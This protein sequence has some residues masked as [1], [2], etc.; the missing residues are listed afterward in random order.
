MRELGE[1]A[2]ALALKTMDFHNENEAYAG[3]LCSH[4]RTMVARLRTV[5]ADKWDWTPDVAAPSA[6]ML[7]EHAYMC[8]VCDRQHL[9][10]PDALK[11]PLVPDPPQD[12]EQM[13]DRLA[14]ETD[15]WEVM[16]LALTPERFAE[17][18]LQF[19][20][21]PRNVRNFVCHAIQNNIYKHGQFATL[22]FALGLDG[23]APYEAPSANPIY[24]QMH[25]AEKLRQEREAATDPTA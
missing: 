25:V 12:P 19:N 10:E 18:R 9:E 20:A 5:P 16:L 8:L 13:C 1:F 6:R 2:V 11:H 23:T 15:R 4:M 22:Y 24:E 7:A 14:E 3:L 21:G 17:G